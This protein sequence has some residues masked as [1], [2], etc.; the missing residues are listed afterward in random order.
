MKTLRSISSIAIGATLLA[1]T[2]SASL[3]QSSTLLYQ[4]TFE[5]RSLGTHWS[6]GT[7]L[8]W[9]ERPGF[10][11]FNGRYSSGSTTLTISQPIL[12]GPR[13]GSSGGGEGGGG[14]GGGGGGTPTIVFTVTFDL[15]AID[16]W[17]GSNSQ[18]GPDRF[19]VAANGQSLLNTTLVNHQAQLQDFRAPDVGPVQLGFNTSWADSIYRAISLD[20]TLPN[21]TS[22]ISIT[23]SDGGLQGLVDES[24]GI[25]NV[26]V[27]YRA[28]P[29]PGALAG[30]TL[31]MLAAARRRR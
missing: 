7:L 6:T 3:A 1:A 16:S 10:T 22:P 8:N 9:E 5:S 30:L 29:A 26:Q 18:F 2:S 31:G 21:S 25:D 14:G 27:S 13:A 17:D 24:W 28:V 23:W 12:P 19:R 20:F 11:T 15:Y 4:N